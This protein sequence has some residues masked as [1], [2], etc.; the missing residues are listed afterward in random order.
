ME[1]RPSAGDG[2]VA[3]GNGA[4]AT[5][6]GEIVL[7]T[8]AGAELRL[9]LDGKIFVNK[10]EVGLDKEVYECFRNLL[11]LPLPECPRTER[12][13]H[14]FNGSPAEPMVPLACVDVIVVGR[15]VPVSHESGNIILKNDRGSLVL[16]S[17]RRFSN[18]YCTFLLDDHQTNNQTFMV[19]A[20]RR[21]M[22]LEPL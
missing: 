8:R 18:G 2:C 19:N 9:K 15:Y 5:E 17:A 12:G 20:L 14:L 22:G 10:L 7:A 13:R 4:L 6:Y 3:I 16:I 11:G 21:L 1:D